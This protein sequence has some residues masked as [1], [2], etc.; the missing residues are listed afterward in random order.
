MVLY[1]CILLAKEANKVNTLISEQFNIDI[2]INININSYNSFRD[3]VYYSLDSRIAGIKRARW[4][5][6]RNQPFSMA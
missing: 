4:R 6:P 3:L 1:I 2:A 5:Q